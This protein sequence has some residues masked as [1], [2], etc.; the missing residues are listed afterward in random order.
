MLKRRGIVKIAPYNLH[1]KK[2]GQLI[3]LSDI[4]NREEFIW[5]VR[6]IM[7]YSDPDVFSQLGGNT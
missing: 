7:A 4:Q 3:S 2:R 6:K 5:T 1:P